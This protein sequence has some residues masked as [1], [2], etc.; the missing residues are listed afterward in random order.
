MRDRVKATVKT[1]LRRFNLSIRRYSSTAEFKRM[2]TI[3]DCKISLVIDVGAN[4]G[5]YASMLRAEGYTGKML[6][7]E[8]LDEAFSELSRRAA[9]DQFWNCEKL[10][11]GS[12]GGASSIHVAGNSFSSSFMQMSK[13]H[14]EAEPSSSYVGVQE[15][16][17]ER[18]DALRYKLFQPDDIIYLKIDV[19]GFEMQVLRGTSEMMRQVQALEV[20]LSLVPLYKDQPLFYDVVEHVYSLGFELVSLDEAFV[21]PRSGHVLQ[22]DGTFLRRRG[23]LVS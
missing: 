6:S 1:L 13:R 22:L 16:M 8:P 18:L 7:F 21:D 12:V 9:S 15:V 11:L 3:N 14:Q 20:E 17:V 4:T 2:K 19:Q 10:A 5:Q 23:S